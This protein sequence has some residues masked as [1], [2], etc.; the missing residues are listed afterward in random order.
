ML[1]CKTALWKYEA[2]L[3]VGKQQDLTF[4]NELYSRFE[5]HRNKNIN[6]PLF[7]YLLLANYTWQSIIYIEDMFCLSVFV[8]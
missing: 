1:L 2:N 3:N 6:F 5:A 8:A 7:C 4:L